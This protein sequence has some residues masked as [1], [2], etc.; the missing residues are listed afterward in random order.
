MFFKKK[1]K[2]EQQL[3]LL[4]DHLDRTKQAHLI[5]KPLKDCDEIRIRDNYWYFNT[6]INR[7]V[8]R[9]LNIF[10]LF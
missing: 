2:R 4:L 1:L 8:D 6:T 9:N 5:S 3:K 10:N 7:W